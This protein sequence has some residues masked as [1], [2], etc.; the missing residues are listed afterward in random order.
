MSDAICKNCRHYHPFRDNAIPGSPFFEQGQC[1]RYPPQVYSSRGAPEAARVPTFAWPIMVNDD[2][3]GEF[4]ER[5]PPS[6]FAV[7][8]S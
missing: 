6:P 8:G 5:M 7:G 2:D 1:R 4:S 3:C